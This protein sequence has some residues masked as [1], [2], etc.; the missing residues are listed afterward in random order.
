MTQHVA[1]PA[2]TLEIDRLIGVE[3]NDSGYAAHIFRRR[4]T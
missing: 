3:V 4:R 1:H 2:Q